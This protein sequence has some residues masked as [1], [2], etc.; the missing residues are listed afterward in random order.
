MKKL[1]FLS[2]LFFACVLSFSAIAQDKIYKKGGDVIDAKVIEVGTT[3]VKYTVSA[4]Q[5]GPIYNLDKARILKIVYQNGRTESFQTNLRDPEVY[6]DQAKNALKVN[7]LAPLSGYFQINFEHNI[8]PGRGYE[9]ALGI[10]GLGKRQELELGAYGTETKYRNAAGAF[11]GAGYKFSKIPDFINNTEKYSHVLQ[12]LYAKPEVIFGVYGQDV[13]S[14][15]L[16]NNQTPA[17]ITHETV[18]FGGLLVNGGKQ[19]VL[20]DAFLI[21]VYLGLGYAFDNNSKKS[22]IL[23]GNHFALIGGGDSGVGFT[24]GIKIG[25]LLNNKKKNNQQ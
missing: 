25:L 12:G 3:S 15:T 22:D 19:W 17:V 18:V 6:A 10:I 21:D 24:G 14:S 1:K 16:F 7:F 2:L 20:G 4:D 23:P 5:S 13:S 11:V 9:L 8:R